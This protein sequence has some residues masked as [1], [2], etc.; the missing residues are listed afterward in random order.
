MTFYTKETH[1]QNMVMSKRPN[2]DRNHLG[3]ILKAWLTM[4]MVLCCFK[5]KLVCFFRKNFIF[6]CSS[7][8]IFVGIQRRN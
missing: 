3:L 8:L 6:L 4:R 2:S 5:L 1:N 7:K